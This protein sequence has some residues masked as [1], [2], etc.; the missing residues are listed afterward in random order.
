VIARDHLHG[1]ALLAE[2]R[3]RLRGVHS[4]LADAFAE[5]ALVI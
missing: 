1:D 5:L 3:Q 4:P 2:V